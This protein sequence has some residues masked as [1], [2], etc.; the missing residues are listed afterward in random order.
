MAAVVVGDA[1][2]AADVL[3]WGLA[4]TVFSAIVAAKCGCCDICSLG[5]LWPWLW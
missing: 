5:L 2:V 3:V 4:A 1:A